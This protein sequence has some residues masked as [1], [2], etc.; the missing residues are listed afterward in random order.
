MINPQDTYSYMKIRI[1]QRETFL[2]ISQGAFYGI[3]VCGI[4]SSRI[5]FGPLPVKICQ[6]QHW[7]SHVMIWYCILSLFFISMAKFM[8]ICVWKHM[9]GMKDDLIVTILVRTAVF[10]S[11]W[12]STTGSNWIKPSGTSDGMCTGIFNSYHNI[13]NQEISPDKLPKPYSPIFWSLIVSIL[14]L[15]AAVKIGRYQRN[16]FD[17]EKLTIIQRPKDLESML[18]NFAVLTLLSINTLGYSLYMKK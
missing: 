4:K 11:V 18:L 6:F 10:I 13:M 17:N 2:Y 7:A 14:F 16:S 1:P 9:R 3:V 5:W 12:V 15:M 8:Y